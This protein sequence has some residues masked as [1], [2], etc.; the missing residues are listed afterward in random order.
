MKRWQFNQRKKIIMTILGMSITL[1]A[2]MFLIVLPTIHQ[3][4]DL[5]QEIIQTQTYLEKQLQRTRH[6]R[7]TIQHITDITA[8][9]K[10]YN[11]SIVNQGEELMIITQL[12]AAA[13]QNGIEQTI[14][15]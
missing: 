3:I 11:L 15:V 5:Q 14:Q 12:E 2:I 7:R 4:T 13:A 10:K 1:S 6:V 8:E 9:A